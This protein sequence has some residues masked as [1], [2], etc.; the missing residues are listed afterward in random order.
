MIF[1]DYFRRTNCSYTKNFCFKCNLQFHRTVAGVL[2]QPCAVKEWLHTSKTSVADGL[3]ST[4]KK[5]QH[6]KIDHFRRLKFILASESPEQSISGGESS[7]AAMPATPQ[8][9][10]IQPLFPAESIE[11]VMKSGLD[12]H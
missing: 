2:C 4:Q 1:S 10:Q 9:R 6:C 3:H 8:Q 12:A 5:H 11:Q 7:D